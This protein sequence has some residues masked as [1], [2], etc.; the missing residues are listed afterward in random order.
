MLKYSLMYQNYYCRTDIDEARV[1]S[2]QV[3]I[4][5]RFFL[6][7]IEFLCFHGVVATRKDLSIDTSITYVGLKLAKLW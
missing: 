5:F 1:I 3:K 2:S 4:Q 6:K 7:K